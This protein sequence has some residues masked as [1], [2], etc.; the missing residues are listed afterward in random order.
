MSEYS[1]DTDALRTSGSQLSSLADDYAIAYKAILTKVNSMDSV[2]NGVETTEIKLLFSQLQP[3][4]NSIEQQFKAAASDL[5]QIAQ[6]YDDAENEVTN[7]VS[8]GLGL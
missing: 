7:N 2:W 4:L 5:I 1:V 3:T 8:C 6:K